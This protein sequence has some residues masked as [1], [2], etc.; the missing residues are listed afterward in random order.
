[1]SDEF[2]V[3]RVTWVLDDSALQRLKAVLA[4]SAE[5]SFDLETTGLNE[6][7][8]N[9]KIVLA[10]F[11]VPSPGNPLEAD[12][13]LLPLYHPESVWLGSWKRVYR[14]V[15]RLLIG[16]FLM[17]HNGKFDCRWTHR[18][19]GVDLSSSLMWDSRVS[20][21][22]LDE[23]SSTKLK[24]RAPDTF[25]VERWDDFDLSEDGAALRVPLID[26]GLYAARDTYWTWRLC[27]NHRV[28][29]Y[30]HEMSDHPPISEDE[31][32]D[33]RLGTLSVW[34]T[35]PTTRTLTAIEQRGILL[36]TAWV[37]AKIEEYDAI[38]KVEK[39]WLVGPALG[40]HLDR[41]EAGLQAEHA[42]FA[43][44][45]H[46]FRRWTEAQVSMGNLK[47]TSMTKNGNPQWNKA[48]L[49]R[50][51]R[52]GSV[53]AERLLKYRDAV[54]KLEFLRAWLGYVRDDGA[55]HAQYNVG[56]LITG[57][58]SS[59]APNMQQITKVLRPAFVPRPGY[60]IA[61]F[62]L[63]QIELRIAAFISRCEPMI[64]AFQRG[65]DLHTMLAGR[66]TS[67]M[68]NLSAV[69]PEERQ[70]GKSANF[71]LLYQM[72]AMGFRSYAETVYDVSFTRQEA[73]DIHR[74]FFEMWTGMREWHSRS[75]SRA[76]KTGQVLSPIGRVRRLPGIYSGHDAKVSHA[77]RAAINAPVQGFASDLMQ[78]AAAIIEG[79]LPGY[80]PV[81]DCR[82]VA[83]VHDSIVGELPEDRWEEVA[84]RVLEVMTVD[85]LDVLRTRFGVEFDVPLE[86][87]A[88]V[89]TRWGLK[90]VGEMS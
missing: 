16:K 65:D 59:Q 41:E 69:T 56:S 70:A 76:H 28:R 15:A 84:K 90:D 77:E 7:A 33:A 29:M 39:A 43:P 48:V 22:A 13:W 5:V 73:E 88:S 42:S 66:I 75:I 74:A 51:A 68:N 9:A 47:I 52:A 50:Q 85:V 1:M 12:T 80:E 27:M 36:D 2:D 57:R 26:L 44:T 71:G 40:E 6:F 49:I 64:A 86:A 82:L 87:E 31:V 14:D 32:E 63:S 37:E 11:T 53:H 67:K 24:E 78:I 20:S 35:M 61:D 54:K 30:I 10:S 60:V 25:G 79:N 19:T 38:R 21:H 72:S 62:D 3:T 8:P 89:G 4:D 83:T 55:I 23:N 81:P 34:C 17:A 18:H 46:W 58:L 45:S